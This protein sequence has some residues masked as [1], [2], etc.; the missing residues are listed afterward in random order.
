MNSF[1]KFKATRL[2]SKVLKQGLTPSKLVL[3]F[4]IGISLGLFPILGIHAIICTGIA[5]IFRLNLVAIQV[6]HTLAFPFQIILF[7]PFYKLGEIVTKNNLEVI[8]EEMVINTFNGGLFHAFEVLAEYLLLAC[9][10]WSLSI[11][12]I[13]L[14][15]YFFLLKFIKWIS[16]Q[17]PSLFMSQSKN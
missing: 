9:L 10:G 8:S 11:L 13:F 16:V 15:I 7:I 14:S 3:V 1:E 2:V 6:A 5:L 12:P 4:S 17:F